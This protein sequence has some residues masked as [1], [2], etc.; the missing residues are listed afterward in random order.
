MVAISSESFAPLSEWITR[1]IA[2]DG[3]PGVSL[4]VTGRRGIGHA[5]AS[6]LVEVVNERHALV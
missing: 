4:A 5:S 2:A 1:R 3:M 6:R